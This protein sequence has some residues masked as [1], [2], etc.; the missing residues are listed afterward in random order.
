MTHA[1]GHHRYI[2]RLPLPN[3]ISGT[4]EGAARRDRA[5]GGA[6]DKPTREGNLG[7]T[8]FDGTTTWLCLGGSDWVM[9]LPAESD[10]LI[11]QRSLRDFD[12]NDGL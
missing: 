9:N 7:D 3:I 5:R 11:R 12:E 10:A 6:M 4:R 1:Y 8:Y 2:T